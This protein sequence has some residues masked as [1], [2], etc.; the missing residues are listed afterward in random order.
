MFQKYLFH[1]TEKCIGA[2]NI[3]I[4]EMVNMR[5]TI[6]K[7]EF[8]LLGLIEQHDSVVLRIINE[9]GMNGI[10]IRDNI[11]QEIYTLQQTEELPQDSSAEASL[12]VSISPEVENLFKIALDSAREMG[13][14]YISAGLLFITMLKDGVG[15]VQEILV[16]AGLVESE[17]IKAYNSLR[18]GRKIEDRKADSKEDVLSRYTTD[19]TAQARRGELDPVIGREDEIMQIIRVL[20]RRNKNNPV[21]IGQPGVGKTVLVEGLAQRIVDA[22]V[23]ETLLGK[24][25]VTLEM[26]ELVAGAKF[27]GDFEERFKSLREEIINASGS[28]ILFIDEFHTVL[29]A[30]GGSEGTASEMLKPALAKGL[31]QCIGAVTIED[32]KKYVETDKALAR[33]LQPIK[34]EEPGVDETIEILKGVIEKYEKHHSI[35][36]NREAIEAAARLSD[37]YISE[38]YLPDKAIDVIDEA[39]ATKHLA[40]IYVPPHMKSVETKKVR[41]LDEQYD[42]FSKK[43]FKRV[44]D[45]QQQLIT[46]ENEFKQHKE[47][48]QE[49]ISSKDIS[50]TEEDITKVISRWTGIPLTRLVETESEKLTHMEDKI[51]K[52]IVGQDQAVSAVCNAIRRNRAGLKLHNR[53]IGSFLFLGPTGVGK[54]ELAKALAEFLLDN[55]NK[56]IRLDMSEYQERHT[57][58]RIIGAPPGYVGYGEG[59]QLTEKV[60]RNPY[61][62]IL[63]DELEKAHHDVF[64]LLLQIF[65][66]G[67]ITD[68]QG[69]EVNFRNTLIIGTSNIGGTILSQE[70]KRIGFVQAKGLEGYEETKKSVMAEVKKFFRPEFINRLDDII[71]FHPLSKEHIRKIVDFELEKLQEGLKEQKIILT[72]DGEIKELLAESGYSETY[73]ARPLKREIERTIENPISQ[74]IIAHEITN[75]M[76]IHA[77]LDKDNR[78]EIISEKYS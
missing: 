20:S 23:P 73:G 3:G 67:K 2:L 6:L 22:E 16:K 46:M 34:I 8:I 69:L 61:S 48:W 25:I 72:V 36:Y 57:V 13:D 58:S 37:R 56:I 5:K 21:L 49:D 39:G 45:I 32:Y 24:K 75:R 19:L 17:A 1:C 33:R 35:I 74:K 60:R 66:N 77:V 29:S 53:P 78:V 4:K 42:A 43:D 40:S 52:R 44:A 62:V 18:S 14:K 47:K 11:M 65:D 38:R 70:V 15:A 76:K 31:L 7:P 68:G 54:T 9:M 63:L 26:A 50:V 12:N 41:L 10:E 28:I 30:T 64:N 55:E 71:V 27:K 59:G 51:H